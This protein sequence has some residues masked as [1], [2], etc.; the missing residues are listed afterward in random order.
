MGQCDCTCCSSIYFDVSTFPPCSNFVLLFIQTF[1][2]QTSHLQYHQQTKRSIYYWCV[3]A[4]KPFSFHTWPCL[5]GL[6]L[7]LSIHSSFVCGLAANMGR[8]HLVLVLCLL[9][10]APFVSTTY[11]SRKTKSFK[12]IEPNSQNSSRSTFTGFFP[13]GMPI[14]PSAPS[15]KHNDIGLQSTEPLP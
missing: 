2:L 15:K 8:G 9:L 7:S 5:S 1:P 12:M 6:S 11:G 3:R 10:L 14:P 13:K 4:R